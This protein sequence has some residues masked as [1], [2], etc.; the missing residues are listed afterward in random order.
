MPTSPNPLLK[1]WSSQPFYLP[2]FQQI[3]PSHFPE[4]LRE[5]MRAELLDLQAI[6]ATPS[7]KVDF[8]TIIAAYDRAGSLLGRV[9]AVFGNM[10]SS[11]NTEELQAIQTEMAP[12]MS[13]HTSETYQT[14]GLFHQIN[15]VYQKRFDLGLTEEQIRLTERIHMDFTRAG[16]AL[17]TAAQEE[18]ADLQAELASLSTKFQQNVMKDEEVW[19]MELQMSDL[20]GCPTSLVEAAAAAASER[21]N[22]EDSYVIT[23]SRSLVEPFLTSSDRRD[24]RQRA[25]KAWV[26]R[27]EMDAARDNTKIAQD[28]LKLR[29]RVANIHGYPSFAAYQCAD[30]MAQT[31]EKVMELLENVWARARESANQERTAMEEFVAELV[32]EQG[33]ELEGG[34]EPSVETVRPTLSDRRTH[35]RRLARKARGRPVVSARISDRRVHRLCS[36][37]HGHASD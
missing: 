14:S 13:R 25:W 23:L 24:L 28:T 34:I 16:A 8:E 35:S 12:V 21:G 2:P 18:L 36:A 3:Q 31:P 20:T 37:R 11:L 15:S 10:C 27:G 6:A 32:A 9:G 17:D 26:S 33:V 5:G 19:G 22:G 29:Q 4:A 30:R 7:E 1:D